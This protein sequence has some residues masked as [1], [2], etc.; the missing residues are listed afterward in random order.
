MKTQ[1]APAMRVEL[2]DVCISIPS[3]YRYQI[4]T[5][6]LGSMIY[7]A[8]NSPNN[9]EILVSQLSPAILF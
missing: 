3:W 9:N 4:N 6:V 1:A 2:W 8:P 5:S 7:Y